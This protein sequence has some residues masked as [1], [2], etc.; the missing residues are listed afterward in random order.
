M[1]KLSE[2]R[3]VELCF[4]CLS[5]HSEGLSRVEIA[6]IICEKYASSQLDLSYIQIQKVVSNSLHVLKCNGVADH[7]KNIWKLTDVALSYPYGVLG[8]EMCQIARR[9]VR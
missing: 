9:L 4:E 1:P 3:V 7:C 2:S 6:D 8:S 5:F